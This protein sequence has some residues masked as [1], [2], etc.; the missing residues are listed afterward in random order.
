MRWPLSLLAVTCAWLA[1][2]GAGAQPGPEAPAAAPGRALAGVSLVS[3]FHIGVPLALQDATVS[4]PGANLGARFSL[5]SRYFGAGLHGAY[6]WIP[7]EGALSPDPSLQSS[8]RTPLRRAV[9]GPFA[10]AELPSASLFTP[11]VQVGVDFN[12][13]NFDESALLCDFWQCTAATVYRFAPG[14][15]GRVAGKLA[16]PARPQ[17]SFDFGLESGMSFPG[18]FFSRSKGFITPFLGVCVVN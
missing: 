13:W 2:P 6:Q 14:L 7:I 9:F 16:L 3:Q 1:A 10:S 17:V 12:F 15:H 11:Y 5:S 4:R 8:G 18:R